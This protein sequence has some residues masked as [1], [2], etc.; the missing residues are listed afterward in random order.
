M[1]LLEG[2]DRAPSGEDAVL[3]VDDNSLD[4]G[5]L[6][7]SRSGLE[8]VRIDEHDIGL[9]LDEGVLQALGAEGIV[10][11]DNGDGLRGA[12]VGHGDPGYT[13]Q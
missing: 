11:G 6:E 2:L 13:V 8:Q 12:S 3:V 10:G 1:V 5:L 9:G 4:I 7:R